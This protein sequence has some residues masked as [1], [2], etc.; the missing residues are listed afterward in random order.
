MIRLGQTDDGRLLIASN[1]SLPSDIERVEY[2]RDQKLFMFVY[3]DKEQEDQLMPCE[4][5]DEVSDIIKASPDVV[6]VVMAEENQES[7]EYIAP[8]VQIGV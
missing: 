3:E 4:V 6:I 7:Y 1:Q 8:L 2:F 5:S